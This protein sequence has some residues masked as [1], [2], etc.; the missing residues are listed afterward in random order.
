MNF[1][2]FRQVFYQR[3]TKHYKQ[4]E[5]QTLY[6]WCVEELEG[7]GRAQ[8]YL[9]DEDEMDEARLSRWEKVI[10]RLQQQEPVQYIF[11]KTLFFGLE[12]QV[13]AR[14]L[15][16][17]PETEELVEWVL[18]SE[19]LSEERVLDIGTGSG[20]IALALK[21]QRPQWQLRACEVSEGALDVARG[22]AAILHLPI[23]FV[24]ADVLG[25]DEVF[26]WG[27]IWVS[28]P[29]YIPAHQQKFMEDRVLAHEPYLALFEDHPLQFFEAILAKARTSGVR[30]VYFETHAQEQGELETLVE[31]TLGANATA[32]F[33]LDLAGKPRFLRVEI[34]SS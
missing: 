30:R 17:R 15:I 31:R 5:L 10:E 20:C 29:P 23:E 11:G 12:L 25:D 18:N 14:V 8:A 19:G 26:D 7:W 13:D 21:S 28:N 3:L 27:S 22:N 4:G 34:Q 6:H 2:A 16:P 9:H 1:G 33:K 32:T 24:Q